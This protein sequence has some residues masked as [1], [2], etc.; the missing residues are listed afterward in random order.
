MKLLKKIGFIPNVERDKD[1]TTTKE[2]LRFVK[3]RGCQSFVTKEICDK[4]GDGYDVTVSEHMEHDVDFFL[5][6]GGD[7]TI[8]H[9]AKTAAVHDIPLIGVNVGNLGYLT[10]V[11]KSGAKNALDMVFGGQYKLEKRMMLEAE[12]EGCAFGGTQIALNDVCVSH[13]ASLRQIEFEILINGEYIDTYSADGI[14]VCT[15][16][17]STAYNL[18]AGGPILRPDS[19]MIAI[20]PICPH[21]LHARSSVMSSEDI[22]EIKTPES[23]AKDIVI[24]LDGQNIMSTGYNIKIRRSKFYTTIIKTNKLGFYDILRQKMMGK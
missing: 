18:S 10:D 9:A 1:L 15:P 8:L 21:T 6:L 5:V 7:G 14:I 22:I 11:E 20:T 23:M 12:T 13:G 2:L 3:T 16:T 19:E 4:I 17:G 24:S